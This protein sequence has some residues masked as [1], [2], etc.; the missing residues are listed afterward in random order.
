MK[1]FMLFCFALLLS[2]CSGQPTPEPTPTASG[3]LVIR[4]EDNSYAPKPEDLGMQ[5]AGVVLTSLDLF[6][7]AGITPVRTE[8]TILGSTPS[9]C[10]ELRIVVNPPDNDYQIFIEIYSIVDPKL[11]CDNVFQQFEA[12]ILL[13]EYSSGVYSIWVNSRFVG[14]IVSY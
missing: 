12:S 1:K 6:E 13:G 4:L 5:K 8:L 9:A 11:N 14:T 2:A 10:H 7:I 3:P